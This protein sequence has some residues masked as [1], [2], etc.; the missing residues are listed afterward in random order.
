MPSPAKVA[1]DLR[2]IDIQA[3]S[4]AAGWSLSGAVRTWAGSAGKYLEETSTGV[5]RNAP[6]FLANI[7]VPG[8]ALV[9]PEKQ[10]IVGAGKQ[11]AK[12]AKDTAVRVKETAG[13][14]A[15]AVKNVGA[16]IVSSAKWGVFVIVLLFGLYIF[17][18]FRNAT[19][20]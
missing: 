17:A 20:G 8:G 10:I 7:L 16:G 5:I 11:T 6:G 12:V 3:V 13:K 1:N 4:Q 14:A 19:K 9:T 2:Q 15:E 18:Q